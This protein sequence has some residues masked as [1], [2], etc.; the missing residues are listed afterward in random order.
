MTPR[1]PVE[2]LTTVPYEDIYFLQHKNIAQTSLS[3]FTMCIEDRV[4]FSSECTNTT[5]AR[6]TYY[7]DER[8]C[9]S[10]VT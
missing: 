6:G 10:V 8:R 7:A 9:C 1:Y 4:V 5:N 3:G 2:I